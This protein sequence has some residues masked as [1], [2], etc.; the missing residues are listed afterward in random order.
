M[1]DEENEDDF[2]EIINHSELEE[3]MASSDIQTLTMRDLHVGLKSLGEGIMY[4]TSF[5]DEF[6]EASANEEELPAMSIENVVHLRN[7]FDAAVAFCDSVDVEYELEN[8]EEDGETEE[9]DGDDE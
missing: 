1:P 4:I 7:M 8:D 3:Y 9:D 6:Y 2:M 5:I